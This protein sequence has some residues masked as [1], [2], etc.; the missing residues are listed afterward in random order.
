MSIS[1]TSNSPR[2]RRPGA[3]RCRGD[4]RPPRARRHRPRR[5]RRTTRRR[6]CVGVACATGTA[7]AAGRAA[8]ARSRRD[9]R[10]RR[11]RAVVRRPGR[12]RHQDRERGIS[13]R[14][15]PGTKPDEREFRCRTTE[16]AVDRNRS[17]VTRRPGARASVGA[18]IRRRPDELQTRC[19][20]RPGHGSRRAGIGQPGHRGRGQLGVRTDRAVGA[21]TGLRTAGTRRGRVHRTVGLPVGAGRVLRHR[22]G[23]SGPCVPAS[24]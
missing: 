7:S 23:V 8:G 11:H 24:V 5:R 6:T 10:R 15:A 22:H 13:G 17:A 12:R 21:A 18:R 20:R 19:G 1:A 14:T 16:Q 9:R 4:R 3:P 2:R